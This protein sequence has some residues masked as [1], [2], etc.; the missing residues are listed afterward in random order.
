MNKFLQ[1]ETVL[2]SGGSSGINLG[3]AHVLASYGTNL[4][5]IAR[6]DLLIHGTCKSIGDVVA[7]LL[8]D[9]SQVITGSVIMADEGMNLVGSKCIIDNLI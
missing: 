7:F 3:I 2:I 4:S 1:K 5:I 8:S 6:G 9:K